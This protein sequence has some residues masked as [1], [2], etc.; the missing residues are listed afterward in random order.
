MSIY[1]EVENP[2]YV[3]QISASICVIQ[4]IL[5]YST[6][7]ISI[8]FNNN[9]LVY[10]CYSVKYNKSTVK[11]NITIAKT[12]LS[13]NRFIINYALDKIKSS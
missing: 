12:I 6:L 2:D 7:I 9:S 8:Q 10:I 4:H 11:E 3:K 5:A 13:Y 1:I